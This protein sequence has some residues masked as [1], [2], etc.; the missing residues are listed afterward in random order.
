MVQLSS[1]S[2]GLL[3]R[4]TSLLASI[5]SSVDV[6]PPWKLSIL[7][8]CSRRAWIFR[9]SGSGTIPLSY[10]HIVYIRPIIQLEML[11]YTKK[12]RRNWPMDSFCRSKE[13]AF[14][15]RGIFVGCCWRISFF[16]HRPIKNPICQRL[17][18]ILR[19]YQSGKNL[20][21]Q[22]ESSS[23]SWGQSLSYRPL[24]QGA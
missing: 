1:Y 7:T 18:K 23:F 12:R 24:S 4:G 15:S 6:F 2:A 10:S 5:A 11:F 17:L 20:A 21:F 9:V 3:I 13:L 14:G 8:R 16:F 19:S 22:S